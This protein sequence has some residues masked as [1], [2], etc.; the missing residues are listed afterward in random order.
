VKLAVVCCELPHPAGTAAGRD[1]WAWCEG[2]RQLGHDLEAWVW[3]RSPSSPEGPVPEWCRLDLFDPGPMWRRHLRAL[4][5]PR[6]EVALAGWEPPP[7]AVAVADHY[8]SFAAVLPF[9]RS[10]A[11]VHFRSLL[12]A[13]AV[14]DLHPARWQTHRIE[15]IAGRRAGLVLAYSERVARHLG[16]PDRPPVVVPMACVVPAEAVPPIEEPVALMLADWSWPPNRRALGWLLAAWPDVRRRVPGARLVLAGRR[17]DEAGIGSIPGVELLGPVSSS[18]E[19]F[20]RASVLAFPCPPSSGPKY[21][22]LDAL[23]HG[24]PVVTTPAG[25][26]G[27]E[28]PGAAGP[29]VTDRRRFASELAALLEDPARRAA[30][31]AAGRAAVAAAHGPVPSARRRLEAM[32]AA[33]GPDPDTTQPSGRVRSQA[34]DSP[35]ADRRTVDRPV[36]LAPTVC[37]PHPQWSTRPDGSGPLVTVVLPTRNRP[38]RLRQ[39]LRSALVQTH[40]SIDIVV[41]DD[42][43]TPP[44]ADTVAEVAGSDPRVRVLRRDAPSGAA[45]ARNAA[46]AVASGELVAFLDDDDC[47]APDKLARQLQLLDERPGVGIVT[48]HHEVVD[49]RHPHRRLVHRGPL[50]I[51]ARHLLWYNLAGSLSCCLVRRDAVGDDL[52]LDETYPSVE[53]WDLWVRCAARTDIGVVDAILGRRTLHGDGRLSDPHSKLAGLRA[54]ERSHAAAMTPTCRAWLRAH[55]RMEVGQGWVKRANVAAAVAS[56]PPRAAALLALEQ[57]ARQVGNRRG[58]HGLVERV[59]TVALDALPTL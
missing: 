25:A 7:G 34:A 14:G 1:L 38:D 18:A 57:T 20:S 33:F 5:R 44:A 22:T 54:F 58:D 41:V 2:V 6:A 42:A 47:W 36:R 45:V 21:K 27:L 55:Q 37:R 49:E 46:L 35:A 13:R 23:A 9:P 48:S 4:L 30:L 52:R 3:F 29:I 28:V 16:T 50:R 24:L 39:A 26:E 11:T 32:T 56:A 19:A 59:L 43:S 40:R 51:G 15:R 12:D 17:L 8:S 31:G 53:D 10:V